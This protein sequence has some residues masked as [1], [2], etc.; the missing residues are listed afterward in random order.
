LPSTQFVLCQDRELASVP[1]VG[2]VGVIVVDMAI[3]AHVEL[4]EFAVVFL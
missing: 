1:I 4:Q 3:I 2:A